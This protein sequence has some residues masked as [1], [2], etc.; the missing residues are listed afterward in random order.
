MTNGRPPSRPIAPQAGGADAFELQSLAERALKKQKAGAFSQAA[1]LYADA[2]KK[3]P[4]HPKLLTNL[5]VC[6]GHM[7]QHARAV[8]A[9]TVAAK[10]LPENAIILGAL[11]ASL[12]RLGALPQA[13]A[14][15]EQATALNPADREARLFRALT[16]EA[17]GRDAEALPVLAPEEDAKP[18]FPAAL[19]A[20]SRLH[21]RAENVE[22][23]AAIA[24]RAWRMEP[25]NLEINAAARRALAQ[26]GDWRTF[27]DLD[28]GYLDRVLVDETPADRDEGYL[29]RPFTAIARLEH[30]QAH[31][32]IAERHGATV[33]RLA[34]DGEPFSNWPAPPAEGPLRIGYIS[35]D[36]HNHAVMHHMIGVFRAHDPAAVTVHCYS[37]GRDANDPYRQAA[38]AASAAFHSV[39]EASNRE[40]AERIHADEIDLLIDLQG[41]T[42][43]SRLSVCAYRPARVQATFLGFPGTLGVDFIDYQIADAVVAPPEHAKDYAELLAYMPLCYQPNETHPEVSEA[44]TTRADWGLPEDGV[45]FCSF[46][47]TYKL[48]PTRFDAW[49]E[50]LKGVE[51][52]VLWL[53]CDHPQVAPNLRR[54]AEARGVSPGRLVFAD[55]VAM[56][57]HRERLRHADLTLDT[58]FYTGHATTA[59]SLQAGVPVITTLGAQFAGRVAASLLTAAGLGELVAADEAGFVALGTRLG[60]DRAALAELRARTEAARETAPL[61][62][63]PR[64]TRELE[65]LYRAMVARGPQ[66]PQDRTPLRAA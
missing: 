48:E 44:T 12:F 51:G 45:V 22:Q 10:Q 11:G 63:A 50:I 6:L 56:P 24:L 9:L 55:K 1:K 21:H 5:G 28:K 62:D 26:L 41:Y 57:T 15:L 43:R 47:Q 61:F 14:A 46:N 36:F 66:T 23:E 39:R 35:G 53:L 17:M 59:A 13:L 7:G 8:K 34:R 38:V 42:A 16:L 18:P 31:R 54:E 40:I 32:K 27:E 25:K 4:N 20:L 60:G 49:M 64:F 52:S 2:L 19:R 30:R 37:H 3:A 33:R 29:G 65:A 58:R